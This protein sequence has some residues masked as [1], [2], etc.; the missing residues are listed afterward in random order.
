[1][2][3]RPKDTAFISGIGCSGKISGYLHSYAFHGV[4]GRALPTATAVKLANRDLTVIVATRFVVR[5]KGREVASV[6]PVRAVV[7]AVNFQ[8][9]AK[10]K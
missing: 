2:G 3:L 7:Q 1:M 9:L 8:K 4:H 6:D 10:L 5:G